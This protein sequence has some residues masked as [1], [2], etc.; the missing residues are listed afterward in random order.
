MDKNK[1]AYFV[2][3]R[4][5]GFFF[6]F[7]DLKL[8]D[9]KTQKR[10]IVSDNHIL[11]MERKNEKNKTCSKI[12]YAIRVANK[13]IWEVAQGFSHPPLPSSD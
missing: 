7:S 2:C 6:L 11:L 5:N 8:E 12:I 13:Y 9:L 4:C 10:K 1:I 3:I